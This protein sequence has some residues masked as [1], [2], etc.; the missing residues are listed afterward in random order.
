[1]VCAEMAV[2]HNPA[3]KRDAPSARPLAPRLNGALTGKRRTQDKCNGQ[4]DGLLRREPVGSSAEP[5]QPFRVGS[6]YSL[7]VGAVIRANFL[8]YGR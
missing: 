4:P 7:K 3:L 6:G 1:M 5:D 2:M 8:A